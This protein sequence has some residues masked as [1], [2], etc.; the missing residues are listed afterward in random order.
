MN[1]LTL[2]ATLAVVAEMTAATRTWQIDDPTHPDYGAIYNRD[3]GIAEPKITGKFLVGCGYLALANAL[4]DAHLLEQADLAAAYLLRARR[5]SGLID[6]ISVNIDSGPDTAFTVQELCTVLEL[7]RSR[8]VNVPAWQALLAKIATFVREAIPAMQSGGFHTPN[9][10]WV[11]VAALVQ[12]QALFPD[13]AVRRTVGSYLA[14]TI[15]LDAEGLFIERSI[16]VYDAVNNRS[17]LLIH[18]HWSC[19]EALPAVQ[20]NLATDLQMLH[21]DGTAETGLSRRQDYGTRQVALGLAPYL[22]WS[23][24]FAPNPAFTAAARW[25]WQQALRQPGVPITDHETHIHWLTYVLLKYGE[26]AAVLTPNDAALHNTE[27]GVPTNFVRHFPLNG[28]HRVR[29]DLLN[30]SFFRDTTRL[31]TLTYG[32]AEL[33]SVKIS[34]TYFGQYIGRFVSNEMTVTGEQVVLRSEGRS[35]PRRPAYEL[36]LGRPVAP[37]QWQAT[38]AERDLRWLPHAV[39]TL[40]VTEV[41]SGFDLRY[42]TLEGADKVAAQLAF[43]FPVGGIWETAD[44]RTMPVAGQVIFL[45]QGWGAMR[46]G[47]DVIQLSPG[48][49]T[50]GMWAMREAES[51]P[52]HVRI[53]LTFLTPVDV[54]VQLRTYRGPLTVGRQ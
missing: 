3:W 18:E 43:D 9:H 46:Y 6:L 53:L 42:Q 24:H 35:N 20:A 38:M 7:A 1:A 10:R 17:L 22:L 11:I 5:P 12:A 39:S 4:P 29:R 40:T 48:H 8:Q 37:D 23:H 14:E 44:T 41:A 54:T 30:A 45:K 50:H 47:A 31:L 34:Q 51:A 16:G 28:I 13:L 25:L 21:A 15:D 36:P 19:P 2:A 52:D 27:N 32:Q 33:S 26:P 49:I